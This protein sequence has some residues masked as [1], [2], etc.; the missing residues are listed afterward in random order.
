M[1]SNYGAIGRQITL[2][3]QRGVF[4]PVGTFENRTAHRLSVELNA[5][6]VFLQLL[7]IYRA[8]GR[9]VSR[10]PQ[11]VDYAPKT[12]ARRLEAGTLNKSDFAAAMDRL[13]AANRICDEWAGEFHSKQKRVIGVPAPAPGTSNMP[14]N[15]ISDEFPGSSNSAGI[16]ASD[17]L[18]HVPSSHPI[19]LGGW[20]PAP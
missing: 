11:S 3:W 19:P 1:K 17:F 18:Q 9:T 5:D 4:V 20:K 12:F 8:E 13:F 14:F 7:A 6:E 2:E 15:S 10:A 16:G